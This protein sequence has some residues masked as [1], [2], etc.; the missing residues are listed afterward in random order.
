MPPDQNQQ[1]PRRPHYHRGRRGPDR[2]GGDRRPQQ[3]PQ[4]TDSSSNRDQLD[5][6]QIMREIRS[7]ISEK[8]G[9]DLTTQQIQD[10]AARRLEAI[11]DPR[12]IKPSLMDELRRASGLPADVAPSESEGDDSIDESALYASKS[13]F[14][15]SIRRLFNSA[16]SEGNRRCAERSVAEDQGGGR[17]GSR[18]PPSADGVERAAFRDPPSSRDGY[19]EGRDRQSASRASRRVA[20]GAGRLQRTP[21]SRSRKHHPAPAKTCH[22]PSRE[23]NRLSS[24]TCST[25]G[26]RKRFDRARCRRPR[27][28]LKG[29]GDVAD[30]GGDVDRVSLVTSPAHQCQEWP[31][32]VQRINRTN[33]TKAAR[34][35]TSLT[36]TG[37]RTISVMTSL[38]PR[39]NRRSLL[40]L[41]LSHRR[42][43]RKSPCTWFIWRRLQQSPRS[44]RLRSL[45]HP[46]SHPTRSRGNSPEPTQARQ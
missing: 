30:G 44:R 15:N 14:I 7:R 2:R 11:L 18:T 20:A 28:R 29:F 32:R 46:A 41:P 33:R 42:Q 16:Q 34:E 21:R 9:I 1:H 27:P 12:A 40:R 39:Q 35:T 38:R 31:L 23:S 6:E 10:L 36:K 25:T 37:R 43:F 45:W 22:A 13:G 24:P 3:Q 19:R 26:R 17:A 5:V 4:Q 8:H